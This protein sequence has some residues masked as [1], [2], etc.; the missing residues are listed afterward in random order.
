MPLHVIQCAHIVL[1]I[2]LKQLITHALTLTSSSSTTMSSISTTH[3]TTPPKVL[4]SNDFE[5]LFTMAPSDLPEKSAAAM[6]LA[7]LGSEKGK[8]DDPWD[9]LPASLRDAEE[10][11]EEWQLHAL[12]AERSGVRAVMNAS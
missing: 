1:Q 5:T 10:R 2:K 8:L 11:D 7:I 4:T 3:S 6:R 12:L 9:H